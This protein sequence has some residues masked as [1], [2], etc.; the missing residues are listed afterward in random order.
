MKATERTIEWK[1]SGDPLLPWEAHI[2][3]KRWQVRINDYSLGETLYS[4]L[5][6]GVT[7]EDFGSW[8]DCWT[9]PVLPPDP[10]YVPPKPI[11]EDDPAQQEEYEWEGQRY[12]HLKE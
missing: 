4:L 5:I 11:N 8:P 9:R 7:K 2:D 6:D 1:L 10:D 12:R 3:G